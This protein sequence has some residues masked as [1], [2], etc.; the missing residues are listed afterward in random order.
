LP[1][2]GFA[3]TFNV[4]HFPRLSAGQHDE[5]SVHELVQLCACNVSI[6]NPMAGDASLTLFDHPGLE[7]AAFQPLSI[8]QGFRMTVSLT[9]DDL[10]L[11]EN[12]T[13]SAQ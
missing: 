10:H 13:G 9:V 4:R 8:G 11:V 1:D 7:L 6:E 5:P 3:S 2:P 12:Y